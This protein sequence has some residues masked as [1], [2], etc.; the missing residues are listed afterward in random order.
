M[1]GKC[2]PTGPTDPWSLARDRFMEDLNEEEKKVF[3]N[4]SLENLFYSASVAQKEHEEKSK[5]RAISAR[6]EP[7]VTA[8]D[9]Y[10]VV[11]DIFSNTYSLAMS[12][13][14]GSI[15]VL[16]HVESTSLIFCACRDVGSMFVLIQPISDCQ[17]I[18]KVLREACRY[19][20][21]NW[22]YPS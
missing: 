2:A 22:R 13:L 21:K 7:F 11:L 12:P 4:A 1:A 10:A 9:Q 6:L 17:G 16:L 3:A 19:V 18:R 8:I 15:R 14:W 20:H 5:S